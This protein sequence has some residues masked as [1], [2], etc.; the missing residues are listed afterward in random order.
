MGEGQRGGAPAGGYLPDAIRCG[1]ALT[2]V[3]VYWVENLARQSL[4][5]EGFTVER[6]PMGR[7]FEIESDLAEKD[8]EVGIEASRNDPKWLV[9]V[10]ATRGQDARM[11]A[12]RAKTAASQ[13]DRFLL[14]VVPVERESTEL[15]LDEVRA[16]MR[17]VANRR[18]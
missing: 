3:R 11:T 16:T 9:E 12:T 7:D 6:V 18:A 4:E 15:D 14:C 2:H 1:N 10:K 5:D 13:K 8:E 17:L